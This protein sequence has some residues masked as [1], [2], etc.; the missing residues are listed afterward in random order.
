MFNLKLTFLGEEPS[1]Y[2][3]KKQEYHDRPYQAV[4]KH[5]D[6]DKVSRKKALRIIGCRP[7]K[8][9]GKDEFDSMVIYGNEISH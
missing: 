1:F 8:S 6:Y 3:N 5:R 2:E 4:D 7:C 9:R